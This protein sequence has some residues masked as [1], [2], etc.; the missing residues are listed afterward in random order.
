MVA[1]ILA[2]FPDARVSSGYVRIRCP[3]HKDGKEKRPSMSILLQDKGT[4]VAGTCHCFACGKVVSFTQLLNDIGRNTDADI[5]ITSQP[6]KKLLELTTEPPIYKAQMPYRKSQYLES[7][8]ISEKVQQKFK[9]YE[10]DGKVNMPIFNREGLYLY[11]NARS[12]SQKMYFIEEHAVKSLWGIEEI[13]LSKPIAVCEGQIDAM[14]LWEANIQAVAT[15]GADNI[16]HLREIKDCLSIV[17]LAFDNDDAGLRARKRAVDYLGAFRCRW[18]DLPQGIDVN[19]A[20]QDIQDIDK[21][22]EFIVKRT[23]FFERPLF[24]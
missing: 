13:D 19:Q 10:R 11:N 3:Y 22:Q 4:M 23:M 14:S 24:G 1:Q 21:F 16:A 9:I 18:L 17:I 15:L 5:A 6:I 12:I 2:I 20:L 8:G 7:R